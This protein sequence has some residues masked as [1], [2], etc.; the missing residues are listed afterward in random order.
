M[1]PL[2]LILFLAMFSTAA[3]AAEPNLVLVT[4]DTA[5]ADRFGFLGSERGLT[6]NLDALAKQSLVFTHAYA[7]APLTTVSHATILTGTHPP[8]HRVND[9]GISIPAPIP[10]VAELLKARGYQTAAFVGSIILDAKSAMAPGF[11][12]G[13]DVY[14]AG[15]KRRRKGD[16]RFKTME[17]RA[18]QVVQ[19]AVAW[20]SKRDKKRPFF[21]WVHVYDPHY[22]YEAPAPYSIKYRRERYDGEIAYTDAAMGTL[23]TALRTS[24]VLSEAGLIIT[25][26]H[27]EALGQHGEHTHG[28]FL[29]D[30]TIH[31]PLLVKPPAHTSSQDVAVRVSHTD[32][33]PTFLQWAQAPVPPHVQGRSLVE[34]ASEEDPD[35]RPSYAETDYPRRA[36]GWSSLGALRIG[37][38]LYINAPKRELYDL[39][40]DP[41]ASRNLAATSAPIADTL[42]VRLEDIFKKYSSDYS[43]NEQSLDPENLEKLRAL[44]YVG[45][46]RVPTEEGKALADPKDK[47]DVANDLHDAMHAVESDQLEKAVTL[48][49]RVLAAD[50]QIYAAQY[51]LGIA[52]SQL[53]RP[54]E[55]VEPLR[56]ALALLRD[57]AM[58]QYELGIALFESGQWKASVP[59]FEAAVA[60]MPNH[61]DAVFSLAAVYAR[62]DRIPEAKDL[63]QSALKIEPEHYRANLLYGRILDLTGQSAGDRGARA[64]KIT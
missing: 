3:S 28:V 63:L 23:L 1:R 43:A 47:I 25:A 9:F 35:D 50:P 10:T 6:P 34:L 58:A 15:Y 52:L 17:R 51:Q 39:D 54:K 26:D 59:H 22:P 33:L 5:R 14:D 38:Y 11:D 46:G 45:G 29:Y 61:V 20:L 36:F 56:K 42:S 13:F 57:S 2:R 44:G 31:I 21:L 18:K 37:K 40:A 7:Q 64:G 4:I 8:Y 48:L 32:I 30:D 24:R 55:A 53:G 19:R 60:Q 16:D 62:T 27:G 49:R 12:R 41:Q